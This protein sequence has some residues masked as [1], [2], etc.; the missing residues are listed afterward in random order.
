MY[1][2]GLR[3]T[4]TKILAGIV[5]AS[6]LILS[7]GPMALSAF[8]QAIR[9]DASPVPVNSGIAVVPVINNSLGQGRSNI[10]LNN[11]PLALPNF[12]PAALPKPAIKGPNAAVNA[13]NTP[14]VQTQ[15]AVQA[16]PQGPLIGGASK[17]APSQPRRIQAFTPEQNNIRG[18][19][20]TTEQPAPRNEASPIE[21]LEAGAQELARSQ[22]SSERRA[23]LDSLFTGSK[24]Q[25]SAADVPAIAGARVQPAASLDELE[26]AAIDSN[27]PESERMDA[28]S[29]I[30]K[31][32]GAEARESLQRV[33]EANPEGGASDYEIHRAALRALADTGLILSLRPISR[34][35]ASE[36]LAKLSR[37]KPDLAIFDYDD[38]LEKWIKPISAETARALKAA[39]DAGVHT[40]ILT[41]RGD[42]PRD[43]KDVT[44]LDSLSPMTPE[45]KANLTVQSSRGTRTIIFDRKGQAQ[46][47]ND[48][49]IAWTD[50]EK[51]ALAEA[52]AVVSRRYGAAEREE[53][54]AYAYFRTLA[55]GLPRD[56]VLAAAKLMRE[57]L[58]ARGIDLEVIGR[59]AAN[60]EKNPPY[61]N[62]SKIDKSIGVSWLRAHSGFVERLQDAARLGLRGRWLSRAGRFL[63][64]LPS[65]PIAA[66]RTLIV[67]DQFFDLKV[68]DRD[69]TKGAPGALAISVG[70][71]ADPRIDNIFVWP[72][73]GRTGSL[74]VLGALG[75]A[76]ASEMNKRAV[77]GL[78]SS[79][80]VSIAVFILTSIAYPF[81]AVPVVGWAG[82]GAL[83]ALGPVAAIATGPLNGLLVDRLSARNAMTLNAVIRVALN[84]AL[85]VL[86][87]AG[88]LNFWTLLIASFANGWLLSSM[89]TTEGAYIKSFAGPK[90]VSTVN[91]LLWMNYLAIQVLLGL[92]FG[93]GTIVDKWN[94]N[95][96]FLL[97]AAVHA[98]VVVPILYFTMPNIRKAAPARK[99]ASSEDAPGLKDRFLSFLSKNWLPAS[100]LAGAGL[101]YAF[102]APL[103]AAASSVAALPAFAVAVL[104]ST[105]PITSALMYWISRAGAFKSLWSGGGREVSAAEKDLEARIQEAEAAGRADEAKALGKDLRRHKVR[106]RTAM[107]YIGLAAL[108]LYPMQSFLLPVMAQTLVGKAA[109]GLLLGQF[110]GSLFLGN[111]ISTSAQAKLP[112]IRLPIIGR[113]PGQRI[114]QAVVIGLG[115]VWL[116]T[117]ILPGNILAAAAAA[118]AMAG[119]IKLAGA[120]AARTWVKVFGVGFAAVW[121]PF[122]VWSMPGLIPF[123]TVPTAVMISLLA[124][125]MF[126]G[127]GHVALNSYFQSNSKQESMGSLIGVQGSF[128]NTAI[129][130]GYGIISMLAASLSPALPPL[131]A[132]C[133][134]AY[135]AAAYAFWRAPPKLP[136]LPAKK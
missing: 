119:L 108:M 79:R 53:L 37:N 31:Q 58:K 16:A 24:H 78:F 93:I 99:Q 26:A 104:K 4:L 97:S 115:S 32:G 39:S 60:P 76:A 48:E 38:T 2:K 121:L 120:L 6:L 34:S 111:L 54:T 105:I 40:A 84:L 45:Q 118:L 36:I 128:T 116:Y 64:L 110:M 136:G 56:G 73:K 123:L 85:P 30:A 8:A 1:C 65:R 28:V 91:G 124:I 113:I 13:L 63:R 96:A 72:E 81:I 131:L 33:S 41:D 5:C 133:G 52:A 71:T 57:E 9:T 74:D 22:S 51:K 59:M 117:R 27:R 135:I 67:G 134:A 18:P 25:P 127:P 112:E 77:L 102:S 11:A 87:W 12:S 50:A 101:L 86:A 88:I 106:L 92:V 62:V 19:P 82:Y 46:L 109:K 17:I 61:L 129:S 98:F 47:V 7:P 55:L 125:G 107:L 130:V 83:M 23:A 43:Q 126:F 68:T 75:K 114:I 80:T 70:G 20:I 49:S 103:I 14:Q 35:H 100:L 42:I 29:S 95:I 15:A 44:I 21:T 10:Q 90:N 69:M 94:P 122:L 3:K 132:F 89:M 66:E